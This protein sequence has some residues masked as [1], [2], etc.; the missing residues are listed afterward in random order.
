MNER[1]ARGT[2]SKLKQFERAI[3]IAVEPSGA[4]D[5]LRIPLLLCPP[6]M[7]RSFLYFPTPVYC[8][9]DRNA[10]PRNP[11][12]KRR[13]RASGRTQLRLVRVFHK[14]SCWFHS[15]FLFLL[16]FFWR[17]A[18]T[19]SFCCSSLSLPD[20]SS[21]FSLFWLPC[22]LFFRVVSDVWL[23][24]VH[25]KENAVDPE[26]PSPKKKGTSVNSYCDNPKHHAPL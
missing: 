15:F 25:A 18:S 4:R 17:Q 8:I 16:G 3:F 12:R 14:V 9:V 26:R 10:D 20:E 5:C 21:F 11:A 22:F 2:C 13:C 19:V 23:S 24:K 7:P 1:K 6:W